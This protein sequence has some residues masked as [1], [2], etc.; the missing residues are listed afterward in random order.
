MSGKKVHLVDMVRLTDVRSVSRT[1]ANAHP[2]FGRKA[3]GWAYR[4]FRV[5]VLKVLSG[6]ASDRV[7][8]MESARGR[9]PKSCREQNAIV[10]GH[11]FDKFNDIRGKSDFL[12][13][14]ILE[15]KGVKL[16]INNIAITETETG[17]HL[18][19]IQPRKNY[20]PTRNDHVEV[21]KA[22]IQEHIVP[23]LNLLAPNNIFT[24]FNTNLP[25]TVE[26]F[27]AGS[28]T[29]KS[30]ADRNIRRYRHNDVRR[31]DRQHVDAVVEV[32]ANAYVQVIA[33]GPAPKR[34]RR[35]PQPRGN[36]NQISL[37]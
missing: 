3:G 24:N 4:A 32:F 15:H 23:R 21:I 31:I 11:F 25:V 36:G 28:F 37:L 30:N 17:I 1:I 22:F 27:D 7:V 18:I 16:F 26:I 12:E 34:S 20:C 5:G 8:A 35:R 9:G 6:V 19:Y 29:D 14:L 33:M 2:F 10:A 13:D